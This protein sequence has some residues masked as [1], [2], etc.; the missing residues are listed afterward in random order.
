M[1]GYFKADKAICALGS[2]VDGPQDIA[3]ISDVLDH[4]PLV[5]GIDRLAIAYEARDA[6]IVVPTLGDR[7]VKLRGIRGDA[8]Q[9]LLGDAP[10]ELATVEHVAG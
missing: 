6:L 10:L 8:A 7:L 3:G 9:A 1:G 4:E 5:D 2:I